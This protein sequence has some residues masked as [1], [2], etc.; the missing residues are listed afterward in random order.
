MSAKKATVTGHLDGST[1][2]VETI[3]RAA[4]NK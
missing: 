1:V 4:K 2:E 3:G